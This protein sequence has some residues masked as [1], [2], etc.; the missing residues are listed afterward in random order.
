M[1]NSIKYTGV[2][3]L[4]AC[5]SLA[6]SSCGGDSSSDSQT[7]LPSLNNREIF[8]TSN[9]ALAEDQVRL[10]S[11]ECTAASTNATVE[12][13]TINFT[14]DSSY[15]EWTANQASYSYDA[16]TGIITIYSGTATLDESSVSLSY[17]TISVKLSVN[18]S[19]NDVVNSDLETGSFYGYQ[20]GTTMEITGGVMDDGE[21]IAATANVLAQPIYVEK[22]AN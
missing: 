18:V 16:S 22:T 17:G 9:G 4:A 15:G 13:G 10:L 1:T 12:T 3:A 21:T 2:A 5:V 7:L 19:L 14:M 6:L 20:S 11:M 8:A